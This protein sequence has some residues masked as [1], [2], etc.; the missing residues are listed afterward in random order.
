M[1]PLRH[2]LNPP[3]ATMNSCPPSTTTLTM[4]TDHFLDLCF[5]SQPTSQASSKSWHDTFAANSWPRI[6]E[7]APAKSCLWMIWSSVPIYPPKCCYSQ[8]TLRCLPAGSRLRHQSVW[9]S[10]QATP[11][12]ELL[13]PATRSTA[14]FRAEPQ[15]SLDTITEVDSK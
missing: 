10:T 13:H 11:F 8:A 5:F 9:Y 14:D 6:M 4:R 12:T 2:V 1:K 3:R 15:I 7:I